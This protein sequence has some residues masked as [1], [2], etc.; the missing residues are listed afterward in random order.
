MTQWT[1]E[2]CTRMQMAGLEAMAGLTRKFFEGFERVMELNFQ[3]TKATL[4][5][6]QD[7][8]V[9]ALSVQNPREYVDLQIE[10]IRLATDS[11]QRYWRQR[12]DIVATTR[13]EFERV[14][15]AQ[16]TMGK[17]QFQ[18]LIEGVVNGAASDS[19][20]PLAAWQEAVKA[21]TTLYES[22]QLTAKQALEV[23]ENSI[24]TAT[25]TASN[26]AP[27]R[28]AQASRATAG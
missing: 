10:S 23:A 17:D 25:E 1:T 9:K 5:Q 4:E 19:T 6:A 21:T 18:G 16:Y 11:A 27:R 24:N 12:A 14:A 28:T 3:T 22:M 2:Q 7:G 26:G 13:A 15:E 20:S 8:V